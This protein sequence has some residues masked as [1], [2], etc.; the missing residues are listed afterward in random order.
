MTYNY[1]I[2]VPIPEA[3]KDKYLNVVKQNGK[4]YVKIGRT[5]NTKLDANVGDIMTVG[6][7]EIKTKEENGKTKITIDNP[8]VRDLPKASGFI[9]EPDSIQQILKLSLAHRGFVK[10]LQNNDIENLW[11]NKDEKIDP[12]SEGSTSSQAEGQ[13]DFTEGMEGIGIIQIH[14]LGLT[15]KE[16]E[17]LKLDGG[18]S[19]IDIRLKPDNK[20]YWEG[21]EFMIGNSKYFASKFKEAIEGKKVL[22]FNFKVPRKS[23]Q[24]NENKP[25]IIKGPL[26]WLEIGVKKPQI[27]KP[28]EIGAFSRSYATMIALEK[29]HWKAGKQTDSNG[30]KHYK[31]FFFEPIWLNKKYLKMLGWDPDVPPL[32]GRWIFNFVPTGEQR[33]WMAS[34]PKEGNMS[35]D[36]FFAKD[37]KRHEVTGIVY[38]P[39]ELDA[40]GDYMTE[41]DILQA[42]RS[43]VLDSGGTIYFHHQNKVNAI[44]VE[45][46]IAPVDF[47]ITDD[48]GN[49]HHIAKGTW[50]MTT[51]VFDKDM[52][53]KI[54][55]GEIVGYSMRGRAEG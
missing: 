34:R 51:K 14:T 23:E 31:E 28:G 45:T 40:D 36:T 30:K 16:A 12:D 2:G 35:K 18:S 21:G 9:R 44:P 20:E 5:Y 29:F 54:E 42:E 10:N 33:I 52:W 19:H 6:V 17:E 50:L 1:G 11:Y 48:N 43:F 7:A 47:D 4:Y 8:I 25:S 46:W 38:A 3:D 26:V 15:E 32:S 41:E 27:F 39:M 24:I 22:R 49:I 55:S 13:L 37:S 53:D